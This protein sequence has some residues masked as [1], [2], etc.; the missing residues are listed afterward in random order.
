MKKR[1][2]KLLPAAAIAL[3]AIV[4]QSAVQ[5]AESDVPVESYQLSDGSNCFLVPLQA[6]SIESESEYVDVVALVDFS[7]AQLSSSVRQASQ[8]ALYSLVENLPKNARVQIYAVSNETE[9]VTDGFLS[10][11]SADL[12]KAIASLKT[13]DALAPPIFRNPSPSPPTPSITTRAP[14]ALSFLSVAA[15]ARARPSTRKILTK[16]RRC[17]SNRAFR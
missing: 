3:T 10:V 7:A 12:Q 6:D 2:F 1:L 14:T 16:P 17:W 5:G 8:D 15:L 11:D 13:R 9:P 4:S